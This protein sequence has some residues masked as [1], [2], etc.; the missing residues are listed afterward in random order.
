MNKTS[1]D[2]KRLRILIGLAGILLPWLV[3]LITRS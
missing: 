1:V 3:V 2:T